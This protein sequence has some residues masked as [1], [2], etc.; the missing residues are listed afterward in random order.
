MI[1]KIIVLMASSAMSK[2]SNKYLEFR[3]VCLGGRCSLR[4]PARSPPETF[5]V[6]KCE[7]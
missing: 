5:V 1:M 2:N 6:G 4:L 7:S 3:S